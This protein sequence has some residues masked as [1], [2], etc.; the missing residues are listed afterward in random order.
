MKPILTHP[1]LSTDRRRRLSAADAISD[2]ALEVLRQPLRTLLTSLGTLVGVTALIIV[3]GLGATG[4]AQVRSEFD[5]LK[6]TQLTV[7]DTAPT[8][9]DLL[10]VAA[11][12][13]VRALPGVTAAGVLGRVPQ[14]Q[15]IAA[16]QV[17][18]LDLD[19]AAAGPVLGATDEGL[20][21]MGVTLNSGRSFDQGHASRGDRVA[22]LGPALASRL[23]FNDVSPPRALFIRN[24][25][26]TV[27]GIITDTERRPEALL[28]V[29]IPYSAA[30]DLTGGAPQLADEEL[31]IKTSLGAAQQVGKDVALAVSPPHHDR[32]NVTVPPDPATLR[33]RIEQ[34]TSSIL[35][36]V[37]VATILLG[38][39]TIATIQ[40]MAVGQRSAEIGIRRAVGA[41]PIHIAF[42]TLL[43]AGFTGLLGAC[44]GAGVGVV[45]L[46]SIGRVRGDVMV[47]N[48]Q[49][50]AFALV[51]GAT[52][53]VVAGAVPA[54]RAARLPLAEILNARNT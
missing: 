47:L 10:D 52:V 26:F 27:I 3:A 28:G 41:R 49:W 23:G 51:G 9:E 39:L 24:V 37:S 25:P 30:K 4:E 54:I 45:V 8:G 43:Q 36:G 42:D 13:R 44:A 6:A 29:I 33:A 12:R 21:A 34:R 7:R 15:P 20:Q 18:T 16:R 46:A 31:L 40:L 11:E 14:D 53:G 50:P 17:S 5:R 38:G 48:P 32:L 1:Q 19:R 2:A 22:L 35:L